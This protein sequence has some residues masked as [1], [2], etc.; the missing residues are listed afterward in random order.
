MR[1]RRWVWVGIGA[2]TVMASTSVP[3]GALTAKQTKQYRVNTTACARAVKSGK[4]V[5]A[6]T[7]R[8][9]THATVYSPAPCPSGQKGQL[10]SVGTRT[11]AMHIGRKPDQLPKGYTV[12][13]VD[14][15][16]TTVA[17]TAPATTSPPTT[18][19]PTTTTTRPPPPPPSTTA[20]APTCSPLTNGGN[21]Y[22][23]GEYCRTSDHGAS[24]VAGNGEPIT[25]EDNNGWRWEPR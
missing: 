7:Y 3:A 14:R 19:A 11:F 21:C 13:R 18:V 16:C 17:S 24:G 12:T 2:A 15:G 25:C 22:E 10:V 1:V 9:C 8:I 23:P 4:V 20:A 6:K 5:T